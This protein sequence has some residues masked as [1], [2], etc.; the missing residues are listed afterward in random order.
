M[1][2]ERWTITFEPAEPSSVRVEMAQ[3]IKQLLKIA[4]RALKLR[5]VE[6]KQHETPKQP[7]SPA[8]D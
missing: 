4:L 5:A 3:K 1:K 7:A 6:V 8:K 2:R